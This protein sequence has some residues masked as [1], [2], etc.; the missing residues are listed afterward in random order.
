MTLL[1]LGSI[2]ADIPKPVRSRITQRLSEILTPVAP[3]HV[4]IQDGY[5]GELPRIYLTPGRETIERDYGYERRSSEYS[6][7]IMV[8]VREYAEPEYEL[9][10]RLI[11]SISRVIAV[12]D[13]HMDSLVESITLTGTRPG[14]REDQGN[15]IGAELSYTIIYAAD[16][17]DPD[18]A[19]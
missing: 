5:A 11:A 12:P 19:I 18:H 7:T 6:I 9:A 2:L 3:V 13:E 1:G 4:G 10:D 16:P 14:Y 8:D 15:M 17:A